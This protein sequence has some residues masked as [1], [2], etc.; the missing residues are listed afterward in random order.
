MASHTVASTRR[1]RLL[2]V[3]TLV[4]LAGLTACRRPD[5]EHQIRVAI[6][7]MEAAIKA[8]RNGDF[9]SHVADDFQRPGQNLDRA[10]LRQLFTGLV[11]RY[12]AVVLV[13][14]VDEI[15]VT[16]ATA[17]ARLSMLATGGQGVL[18][19]AAQAWEVDTDW[20]LEGSQWKL[21]AADWRG[22]W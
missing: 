7:E 9:M 20:R 2:Q 8:R 13:V 12:P 15:R 22:Q 11:L 10:G 17:T 1:R 6:G 14:T 3:L 18:P 21:A 4:P 16:G 19:E 5:P